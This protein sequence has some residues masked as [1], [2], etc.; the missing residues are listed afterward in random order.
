M[1]NP[2]DLAVVPYI[3]TWVETEYV[4]EGF[5]TGDVVPY[6]GTWVE[7]I[8]LADMTFAEMSYLI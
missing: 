8:K 1:Y 3:G 4:P 6:I 5:G 7:T 2:E